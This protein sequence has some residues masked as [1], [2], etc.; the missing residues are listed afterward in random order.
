MS[1]SLGSAVTYHN[2]FA[3]KK[4]RMIR[5]TFKQ[6]V[7]P[8]I[9]EEMLKDPDK[10]RLGG[11]RRELTVLF[12]DIRGFT[13]ISENLQPEIVL[14]VL[15]EYLTPMTDIVFKQKG[16]FDKYMGDAIMAI[17]NA[18]TD[19]PDHAL[20]AC[21]AALDMKTALVKLNQEWQRT[22]RLPPIKIGIGINTGPMSVGYMGSEMIKSYTVLGDNVN[23][24]SRLEGLTK[25]YQTD[26]AVSGETTRRAGSEFCF[27][28][29]DRV[30]VK[31]KS[32]AVTVFQ[33][34]DLEKNLG[35]RK[36]FYDAYQQAIE[37][38]KARD[39]RG[40]VEE[41]NKALALNPQDFPT[42]MYINR[43]TV[44]AA[45]PPD[46]DWDGV[47]TLESK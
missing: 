14:E 23:L 8:V 13:S 16:T 25:Y 27:R 21:R 2:F 34:V 22:R 40:A 42:Q 47:V 7:S 43:A 10:V 19:Q 33:L 15:N 41:F 46:I 30:R 37:R 6:V 32:K 31:G 1:F 29:L 9:V 20:L 11:E 45:K 38:Y 3:E 26:L 28:E 39:F 35:N 12:S 17:W 5:A 4:T 36:V 18:P 44:Y 24:G